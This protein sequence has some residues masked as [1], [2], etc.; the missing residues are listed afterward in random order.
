MER[1]NFSAF[2]CMREV[3]VCGSL[4]C[5]ITARLCFRIFVSRSNSKVTNSVALLHS[6]FDVDVIFG[7][8]LRTQ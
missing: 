7:R 8:G 3:L 5:N 1:K 6:K 4:G 2:N